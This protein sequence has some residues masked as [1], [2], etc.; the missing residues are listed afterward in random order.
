MMKET[1][2]EL[3]LRYLVAEVAEKEAR[4]T[5]TRY[6]AELLREQA[7][8][9]SISNTLETQKIKFAPNGFLARVNKSIKCRLCKF[10]KLYKG[11]K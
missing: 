9:Q 10:F 1:K 8:A 2:Q 7:K 5:L 11:G 4:A 3:E 6:E